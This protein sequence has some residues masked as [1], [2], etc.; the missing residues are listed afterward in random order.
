YAGQRWLAPALTI[1]VVALTGV[2]IVTRIDQAPK[3]AVEHEVDF[4]RAE[5]IVSKRCTPC[6]SP[7]PTDAMF[8]AP[9]KNVVFDTPERI[10]ALAPKIK[11]LAVDNTTM[12]FLNRTNITDEERAELGKWIEQGAKV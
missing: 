1:G 7:H 2:M 10:R 5:E 12:P 11:E 4:A 9:P 8:S 3:V 6:H